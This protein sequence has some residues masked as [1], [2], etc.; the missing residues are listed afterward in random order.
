MINFFPGLN[1]EVSWELFFFLPREVK[2]KIFI[3]R[4]NGSWIYL[5]CVLLLFFS[6]FIEPF[7]YDEENKKK[8]TFTWFFYLKKIEKP[9]CIGKHEKKEGK[10]EKKGKKSPWQKKIVSSN[11]FY[12]RFYF[13]T[14][15]SWSVKPSWNSVYPPDT[16]FFSI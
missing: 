2:K 5:I 15:W 8:K 9:K 7:F 14:G 10:V 4:K 11:Y 1:K 13:Q 12:V 3:W 16:I 6:Y